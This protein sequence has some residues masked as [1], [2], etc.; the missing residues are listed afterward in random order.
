M[1]IFPLNGYQEVKNNFT[2]FFFFY[3]GNSMSDLKKKE[4]IV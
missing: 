3:N 2:D 1:E 4:M